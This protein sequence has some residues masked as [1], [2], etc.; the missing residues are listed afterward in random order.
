[1]EVGEMTD[2][3]VELKNLVILGEDEFGLEMQLVPI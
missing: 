2:E 3:L 1:M